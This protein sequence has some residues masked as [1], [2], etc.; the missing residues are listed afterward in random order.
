MTRAGATDLPV[1][2]HPAPNHFPYSLSFYTGRR[3]AVY[4]SSGELSYGQEQMNPEDTAWFVPE[5]RADEQLPSIASGSWVLTD[6]EHGQVLRQNP[7][8]SFQPIGQSGNKILLR[9]R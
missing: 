8:D 6:L 9:K 4:G 7:L 3:V 5:D 2:Y 1:L